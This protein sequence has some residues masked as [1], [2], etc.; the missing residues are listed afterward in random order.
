MA[1]T[2]GAVYVPLPVTGTV[3]TVVVVLSGAVRV[4]VMLP[5][6]VVSARDRGRIARERR[7]DHAAGRLA[8]AGG[9]RRAGIDR[10]HRFVDAVVGGGPLLSRRRCS[11]R[12]RRRCRL[13]WRAP[14]GAVYV[15]GP[16]T[17]T[18]PTVVVLPFGAVKV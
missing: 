6:D 18:V 13:A 4:K 3:P 10:R 1:V 9:D 14:S 16:V 11:W 12:A 15:P 7:A 8:G 2:V 17:G 5:R